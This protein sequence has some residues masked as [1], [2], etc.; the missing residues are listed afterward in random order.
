MGSGA[1]SGCSSLT[2]ITIPEDVTAIGYRTFYGCSSLTS[3]T[4]PIK[5][6]EIGDGAFSGCSNLE[7]IIV[8]ENNKTYYSG[9]DC[10]AIIEKSSKKLILGCKN[11]KI[12]SGVTEIGEDAFYGCSGLT[13]ITIPDSVTKITVDAWS[14]GAFSGCSNL[15]SIIVDKNN[16]TYDSRGDCNAIIE[17]SSKKLILGCKNTKIPSGVTT[18]D[19][20]AFE[21]C[22]GLTSITIPEGVTAIAYDAFSGCSN[23]ESIIVDENN[24]TYDSRE[25]CNA[26]I[27]TA[28]NRLILGCKNTKIPSGV[29]KIDSYAFEGCS[30]LTNIMIPDSVTKIDFGAFSGCSNLESIIVDENNKTYDSRED[31]NAIIYTADNTLI[32]G[33]K[34]TTIPSDVTA[35]GDCAFSGCSSLT[36]ITLP[37]GVTEIGSSAFSGCSGLANITL[38]EGVTEIWYG[39]FSGCSSLTSITIPDSVTKIADDDNEDDKDNYNVFKNCSSLKSIIWKGETYSSEK[40]FMNAFKTALKA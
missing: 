8:D 28:D 16:E 19:S 35:I 1:F 11:T 21:G 23:L 9:E 5:V 10:N 33:C 27:Y 7:S 4:I 32:L 6:K 40:K 29:T 13:S 3:I 24:K 34:K 25:D 18:I 15:E 2:S 17:K 38:P 30:G 39:A 36:N 22:S 31:C 20:Y 14:G 12:P 26:I 37:E